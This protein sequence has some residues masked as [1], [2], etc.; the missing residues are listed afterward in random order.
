MRC[1]ALAGVGL[2]AL[3]IA[4]TPLGAREP[5]AEKGLPSTEGLL[6]WLDAARQPEAW[7]AH[8]RPQP[9]DGALLDVFYDGSGNGLHARQRL[10]DA[11]PRLVV[12]G[13]RTVVRF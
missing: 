8:G 1:R 9:G 11:Q 12:V 2:W 5:W 3:W 10:R 13:G 4:T 6:W 7:K